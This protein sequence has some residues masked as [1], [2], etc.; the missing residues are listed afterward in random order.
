MVHIFGIPKSGPW[1]GRVGKPMPPNL[2]SHDSIAVHRIAETQSPRQ[3]WLENYI[4]LDQ[5]PFSVLT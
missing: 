1:G 4:P 3:L 5:S 2:G